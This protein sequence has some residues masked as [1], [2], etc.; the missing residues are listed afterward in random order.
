[1]GKLILQD[2]I[3]YFATQTI[4]YFLFYLSCSARGGE[5]GEEDAEPL[6][7]VQYAHA[8]GAATKTPEVEVVRP[9]HEDTGVE[10][11]RSQLRANTRGRRSASQDKTTR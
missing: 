2:S 6:W 3:T 5:R 4:L 10:E 7:P 11:G 9:E 1:M 8:I